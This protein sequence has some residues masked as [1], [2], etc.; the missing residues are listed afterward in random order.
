MNGITEPTGLSTSRTIIATTGREVV[1]IALR[2]AC[3]RVSSGTLSS[4]E[5]LRSPDLARSDRLLSPLI[6]EIVLRVDTPEKS[7]LQT[8]QH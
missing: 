4:L 2:V 3:H 6:P 8:F 1:T 7:F 5:T